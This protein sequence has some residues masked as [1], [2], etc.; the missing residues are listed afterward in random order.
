MQ[1]QG[2]GVV[3]GPGPEALEVVEPEAADLGQPGRQVQ[4]TE[5]GEE[6]LGVRNALLRE[7]L[8]GSALFGILSRLV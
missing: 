4:G 2:N 3:T 7:Y 5:R 6:L 1:P 8:A